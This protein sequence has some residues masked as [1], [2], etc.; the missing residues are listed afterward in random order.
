[1]YISESLENIE[2][3]FTT[4]IIEYGPFSAPFSKGVS[5]LAETLLQRN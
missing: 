3:S 4:A 2:T 1:M 5:Q